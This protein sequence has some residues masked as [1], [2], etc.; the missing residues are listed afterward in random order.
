MIGIPKVPRM[1]SASQG[2]E[3]T[4]AGVGLAELERDLAEF[5]ERYETPETAREAPETRE[6]WL[7][8]C[9]VEEWLATRTPEQLAGAQEYARRG[10]EI[11]ER[12]LAQERRRR[13]R[14]CA[15][16]GVD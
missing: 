6:E 16:L 1:D 11:Y 2:V 13:D 5:F 8:T 14:V 7:A 4:T 10:L 9:T 12:L 15:R 3:A